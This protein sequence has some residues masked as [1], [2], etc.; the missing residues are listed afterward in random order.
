MKKILIINAHQK[1]GFST[2]RLNSSLVEKAVEFFASNN[3][4]VSTSTIDNGY[5]VAEE[6]VKISNS[7]F[8]IVQTPVYWMSFPWLFKKYMDEV[9]SGGRGTL[10]A[11]DGRSSTDP[12]K[13]YGTG[14]LMKNKKYMLSTT[15]NA[16]AEALEETNQLFEGK[17][18]D[19]VFFGFHKAM[20]FIGFT[21]L[22]SFSCHDVVKQPNVENVFSNYLIHLKST[23]LL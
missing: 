21:K 9:F 17:G 8:V 4:E 18:V 22:N 23:F 12:N 10:Y 16:P 6:V 15:W 2:G 1:V 14:G 19:T 7:D 3:F 20:K 5:V 11:D 13:K